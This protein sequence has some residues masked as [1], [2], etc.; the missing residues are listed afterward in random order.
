L[1]CKQK[2]IRGFAK[3]KENYQI[4]IKGRWIVV[5]YCINPAKY[6]VMVAIRLS[7]H[8]PGKVPGGAFVESGTY[9]RV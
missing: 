2:I 5:T 7:D 4:S 6:H 1:R 9:I 8:A 3:A